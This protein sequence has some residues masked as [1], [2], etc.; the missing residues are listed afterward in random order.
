MVGN[1]LM[2]SSLS[3]TTS[4]GST[5][6]I[7]PFVTFFLLVPVLLV[8]L[9]FS[10]QRILRA[11]LEA[12]CLGIGMC[13]PAAVSSLIKGQTVTLVG[14]ISAFAFLL[15][16]RVASL[17][18]VR[19]WFRS[20]LLRDGPVCESCG[21]NLTGNIGGICPECGAPAAGFG[22]EASTA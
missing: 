20:I 16:V 22:S 19:R 14:L 18:I 15:A 5:M 10:E 8:L 11:S 6:Y 7:A 2:G 4:G 12:I 3:Y 21:Y 17:V 1:L 13:T 9:S